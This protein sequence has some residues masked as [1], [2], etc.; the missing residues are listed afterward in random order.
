MRPRSVRF[1]RSQNLNASVRTDGISDS[2]SDWGD[3][4]DHRMLRLPAA[5][6]ETTLSSGY[7]LMAAQETTP[8]SGYLLTVAN[9]LSVW[10]P[11]SDGSGNYSAQ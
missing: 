11:T 8:S 10:L 7:R 3:G 2:Q 1:G 4:G 5:A 9:H 6:Q